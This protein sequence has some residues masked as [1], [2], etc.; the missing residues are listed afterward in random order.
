MNSVLAL[1]TVTSLIINHVTCGNDR[2]HHP[3][4]KVHTAMEESQSHTMTG[5]ETHPMKHTGMGAVQKMSMMKEEAVM[6]E[7]FSDQ[8]DMSEKMLNDHGSSDRLK[9]QHGN[10]HKSVK[11]A[12]IAKRHPKKHEIKL[13]HS[14]MGMSM[15]HKSKIGS[16]ESNNHVEE[17]NSA[18]VSHESMEDDPL[19]ASHHAGGECGK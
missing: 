10:M 15:K 9:P 5:S 19:H 3:R 7:L 18:P 13:R 17:M 1:F 8:M 14:S 16:H 6:N 4:S 2:H 12:D 11:N